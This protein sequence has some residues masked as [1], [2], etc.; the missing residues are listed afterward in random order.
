VFGKIGKR[1]IAETNHRESYFMRI[2]GTVIVLFYGIARIEFVGKNPD[3]VFVCSKVKQAVRTYIS[4]AL[5]LSSFC[6]TKS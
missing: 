5:L 2:T 3:E 6:I 4:Q 1:D